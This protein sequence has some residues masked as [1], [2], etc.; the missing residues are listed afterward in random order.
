MGLPL[1]DKKYLLIAVFLAFQYIPFVLLRFDQYI[2]PLKKGERGLAKVIIIIIIKLPVKI[3]RAL[4][5]AHHARH[6]MPLNI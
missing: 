4:Q 1:I 2:S 5:L 6:M 3:R